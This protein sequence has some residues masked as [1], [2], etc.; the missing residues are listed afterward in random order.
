MRLSN[1]LP[2]RLVRSPLFYDLIQF[3]VGLPLIQRRLKAYTAHLHAVSP[4]LDLGAGTG[5]GRRLWAPESRYVPIDVDLSRLLTF[6]ARR[7][8]APLLVADATETPFRA[9]SASLVCALFVA[10]HLAESQLDR[11]IE[12]A[13]RI[14]RPNGSFLILDPLWIPDRLPSRLL[15]QLDQGSYPRSAAQLQTAIAKRFSIHQ[16]IR[17]KLFHHYVF[18]IASPVSDKD[19]PL[20]R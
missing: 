4:V 13:Y 5:A 3:L 1:C 14:L 9:A 10:H 15:W 17:I 7:S 2:D 6:R 8:P 12:E 20:A 18:F 16:S 19:L 11:M